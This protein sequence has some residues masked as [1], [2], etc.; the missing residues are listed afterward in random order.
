MYTRR[1]EPFWIKGGGA[2]GWLLPDGDLFFIGVGS[3]EGLDDLW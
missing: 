2:P 3:F 1:M